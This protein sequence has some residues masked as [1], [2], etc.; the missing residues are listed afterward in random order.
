[1]CTNCAK[2]VPGA[3][4]HHFSV[5]FA[6]LGPPGPIFAQFWEH[7]FGT[8]FAQFLQNLGKSW[9]LGPVRGQEFLNVSAKLGLTL[10]KNGA[11]GLSHWELVPLTFSFLD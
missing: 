3:P 2:I 9:V 1:M 10:I 5:M 7:N 4:W 8:I 11:W 6:H